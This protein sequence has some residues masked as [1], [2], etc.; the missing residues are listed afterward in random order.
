MEQAE[1][2][3]RWH[4]RDTGLLD[5]VHQRRRC[6]SYAERS[7]TCATFEHVHAEHALVVLDRALRDR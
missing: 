3:T 7:S 2:A 1:S 5:E 6:A 4:R